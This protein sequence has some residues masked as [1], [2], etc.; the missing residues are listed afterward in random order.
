MQQKSLYKNIGYLLATILVVLGIVFLLLVVEKVLYERYVIENDIETHAY[1]QGIE[2]IF[3]PTI[4]RKGDVIAHLMVSSVKP[5]FGT[6]VA[7]DNYAVRFDGE[8]T[9][10]GVYRYAFDEVAD[11]YVVRF[12]PYFM[13]RSKLPLPMGRREMRF[14]MHNSSLP[15]LGLD[16]KTAATGRVTLTLKNV[17]LATG[18]ME[19][20]DT[21]EI[22]KVVS[23]IPDSN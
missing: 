18:P 21:A 22:L 16:P 19:A 11:A 12:T 2:N 6:A 8:V 7:V 5:V 15:L 17:E 4:V 14:R 3:N 23:I 10:S 20:E 13:E 1:H 9:L